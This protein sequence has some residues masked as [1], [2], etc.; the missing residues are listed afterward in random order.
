MALSKHKFFTGLARPSMLMGVPSGY[1]GG[2]LCLTAIG[3]IATSSFYV[4]IFAIPAWAIGYLICIKDPGL[5]GVYW[6][7]FTVL[8]VIVRNKP[9]W[10]ARSYQP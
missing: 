8:P 3:F 7:R 10:K 2:I 6:T 1:L 4:P 5:M 9:F